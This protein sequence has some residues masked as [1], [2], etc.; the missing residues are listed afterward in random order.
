MKDKKL[1]V[2]ILDMNNNVPNQ[3][4]R[5]I[6][7]MVTR[8]NTRL[9]AMTFDVRHRYEIPDTSFDIY[10]S[11]GGPGSPLEGDGIWDK[12]YF[13][14][15]DALLE[16]NASNTLTKK[17][18]FLIC[19]SFEMVAHHLNVGQITERKSM[20]FG[21][22][23]THKTIE[24]E[25][26]PLFQNLPNPFCVADFRS[27]QLIQPNDVVLEKMDAKILALEKIRPHVPLERSIMAIRFTDEMIG[28][29]FHP[30][31]D[32]AGM[33]KYFSQPEKR[34]YII[35]TYGIEKFKTMIQ[36]LSDPNKIN[37]THQ[38]ILPQFLE[39]I[40]DNQISN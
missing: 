33:L 26:E 8:Y 25:Q 1:K 18:I 14:L 21:T 11:S 6:Q 9:E 37:N 17:Y 10:I 3:G 22:F 23:P 39:S 5:C 2:A 13:E 24:G 28:T 16:H 35:D 36:D 29:Q 12:Q 27:W 19:H 32:A 34:K 31:A 20:A 7:E 40:I 38:Q 4:L 15:I 30:E